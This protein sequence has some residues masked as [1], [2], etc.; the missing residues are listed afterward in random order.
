MT[1]LTGLAATVWSTLVNL[2]LYSK[3]PLIEAPNYETIV[4][5]ILTNTKFLQSLR[6]V[7]NGNAKF[8]DTNLI[9]ELKLI[10][11]SYNEKSNLQLEVFRSELQEIKDK[12]KLK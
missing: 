2:P 3:Q 9:K 5:N 11:E 8:D 12:L 4:E 1:G 10:E 7:S 6:E